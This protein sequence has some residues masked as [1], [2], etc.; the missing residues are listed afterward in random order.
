MGCNAAELLE[1]VDASRDEVASFIG[2]AIV[3]DR[4]FAV[5]SRRDHGLD[6]L[7]GQIITNAGAV[8]APIAEELAGAR[9]EAPSARRS[10]ASREPR[11][12]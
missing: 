6:A 12:G 9:H 7:L 10:L 2:L 4:R 5:R 8:V 3:F 1:V 11:L